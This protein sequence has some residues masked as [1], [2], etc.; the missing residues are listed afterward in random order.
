MSWEDI[1]NKEGIQREEDY[2]IL[3]ELQDEE[4][5]CL[6]MTEKEKM[7]VLVRR[8]VYEKVKRKEE[9]EILIFLR[10]ADYYDR[11]NLKI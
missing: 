10:K 7:E 11:L 4:R 8:E 2:N 9:L 6:K 3:R 5:R 1:H